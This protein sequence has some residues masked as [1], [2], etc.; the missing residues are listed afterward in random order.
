MAC[1]PSLWYCTADGPVEVAAVDVDGVLTYTP[2]AGWDGSEP[3]LTEAAAE[4][5]CGGSWWCDGEEC[6]FVHTDDDPPEGATGPYDTAEECDGECPVVPGE[7][8]VATCCGRALAGELFLTL[9]GGN[10]TVNM[11]WDGT[12][13]SGSRTF[14]GCTVD[15]RYSTDC[16][17][18]YRCNPAGSW[19]TATCVPTDPEAGCVACGPP[20]VGANYAI[21]PS[22]LAGCGCAVGAITGSLSE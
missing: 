20:F 17:L 2:P 15:F 21:T 14:G 1:C 11:V 8:G 4:A 6:V 13:W 12:Y 22:S 5:A 18:Q 16:V 9:S 3:H 10:G 7:G 19:A